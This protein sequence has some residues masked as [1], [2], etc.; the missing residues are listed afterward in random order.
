MPRE[1]SRVAQPSVRYYYVDES[2]DPTLFDAKGRVIVGAQG[3]S[4]FFFLGKLDVAD[5]ESLAAELNTLRSRLLR[6]PYFAGVPSMQPER[7]KTA[8]HFH[9]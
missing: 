2:G 6:E 3:R 5:P 9:A 4:R 8:T 7:G 1:R